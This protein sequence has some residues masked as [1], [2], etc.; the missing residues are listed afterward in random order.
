[1]TKSR[2]QLLTAQA[3]R[4]AFINIAWQSKCR[5][6]FIC[7]MGMSFFFWDLEVFRPPGL[8]AIE[9]S[10]SDIVFA[11]PVPPTQT[12]HEGSSGVAIVTAVA[13]Q[14]MMNFND[15]CNLKMLLAVNIR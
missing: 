12:R 10:S 13:R 8:V 9:E 5:V 3:D 14:S 1:M 7:C 6:A 2:S 15:E 4:L 11:S